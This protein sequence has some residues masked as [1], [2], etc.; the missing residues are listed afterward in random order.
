MTYPFLKRMNHDD[1]IIVEGQI[2]YVSETGY[3]RLKG[4]RIAL[5][6]P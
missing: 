4:A 6:L 2:S 1:I 5:D 3:I